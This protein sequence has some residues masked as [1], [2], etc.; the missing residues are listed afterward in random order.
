MLVLARR[1]GQKIVFPDIDT[2]VQVAEARSGAVRL[3]IDGP[4][5]ITVL[6]EEV[7]SR[8]APHGALL[9]AGKQGANLR[10]LEHALRNRLNAATLGLA[11]LRRQRELG[12]I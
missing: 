5:D 6:R 7:L 11:L 9:S 10:R 2:T 8:G 12:L 3:G 4:P 1:P